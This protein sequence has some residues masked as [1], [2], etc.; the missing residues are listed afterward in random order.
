MKR[1]IPERCRTARVT[2]DGSAVS[3]SKALAAVARSAPLIVVTH[4][5][6]ADLCAELDG[7]EAAV[8]RLLTI[9][10]NANKPICVN[11]ATGPDTSRTIVIGPKGWTEEKTAGWIA[12]HRE[13]LEAAFGAATPI[14]LE[15]A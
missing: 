12:P 2:V 11:F 5:A 7:D 3:P 1:H 13:A 9:A 8:R 4:R 15:D 6:Y 10:T 14:R